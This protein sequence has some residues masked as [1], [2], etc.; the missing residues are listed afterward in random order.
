M[1][2]A[3]LGVL[4]SVMLCGSMGCHNASPRPADLDTRNETSIALIKSQ[5]LSLAD[6]QSTVRVPP[7]DFEDPDSVLRHVLTQFVGELAV[8]YPSERYYYYR[9][10]AAERFISG[11]IRFSE[12]ESGTISVGYFDELNPSDFRYRLYADG[13]DGVSVA[14]DERHNAVRV[15]FEDRD[16]VFVLYQGAFEEPAFAVLDGE[17]HVSGLLDES[18]YSLHLMYWPPDRALYY[19]LNE[20][21]PLP[22]VLHKATTKAGHTVWFGEHSRF[23]FYEHPGTNR[24][25]LVGV[26]AKNIEQNNWFDGPFDQVPPNLPIGDIIRTAYP[27]VEDA[28][29]IDDN[30]NFLEQDGTRIA[31][32][33]YQ[34]YRS[35]VELLA[36]I[37]AAIQPEHASP[38][39]WTGATYE[40]KMDWRAPQHA[41]ATL[42]RHDIRRSA[43]WP[44]NHFGDA[45][46]EWGE[47][48]EQAVSLQ[49][50]PNSRR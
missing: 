26:A 6:A 38:R 47:Q 28:G 2:R 7:V 3:A 5:P 25:I 12:A 11:N 34:K 13:R 44:P 37:D 29:G 33:P 39:A 4:G 16:H 20:T 31:I 41:P 8:V 43:A 17:Q 10:P 36:F 40:Y 27:Y 46:R 35:G 24:K 45:S 1:T 15:R 23:C 18:G 19:V 32:T 50:A 21:K 48:H 49:R 22:E 30:G 9:F 14:Y 42:G